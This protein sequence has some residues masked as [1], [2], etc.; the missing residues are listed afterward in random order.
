MRCI[1]CENKTTSL[2]L[3]FLSPTAYSD[4][5]EQPLP[6]APSSWLHSVHGFSQPLNALLPLPSCRLI[7][8]YIRS[9][10]LP[11]E[12][13]LLSAHRRS[14]DTL[15]S[16]KL[17]EQAQSFSE[18]LNT[19]KHS[20]A[21]CGLNSIRSEYLHGFPYLQGLSVN[22]QVRSLRIE[23]TPLVLLPSQEQVLRK[24]A[25]RGLVGTNLAYLKLRQAN[26]H[27]F[28]HLI[29]PHKQLSTQPG[30]GY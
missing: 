10:G 3:R 7:P 19:P 18:A 13:L 27:G 4:S 26:L 23:H 15:S 2:L 14:L 9:W 12:V 1:L 28:C 22:S 29:D 25:P 11:F 17:I 6:E 21:Y 16:L 30:L 24:S 8:S 20:H 5:K